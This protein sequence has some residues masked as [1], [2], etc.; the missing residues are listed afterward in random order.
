MIVVDTANFH[1]ACVHEDDIDPDPDTFFY[2]LAEEMI[3]N[4]L[5]TIG[6]RNRTSTTN[7]M[8]R[9]LRQITV[10]MPH[11]TPTKRKKGEEMVITLT[12]VIKEGVKYSTGRQLTF[13]TNAQKT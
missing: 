12:T 3:D 1:Q 8:Q 5:D 2:R 6:T 9:R 7:R 10:V 11:L 13:E 4:T